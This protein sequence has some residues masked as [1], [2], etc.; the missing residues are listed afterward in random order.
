MSQIMA[1]VTVCSGLIRYRSLRTLLTST[2]GSSNRV[3]DGAFHASLY[4]RSAVSN[5]MADAM[6]IEA[7]TH[8]TSSCQAPRIT[9]R[10]AFQAMWR[11][12]ESDLSLL[13]MTGQVHRPPAIFTWRLFWQFRR[14]PVF[15]C[16]ALDADP[17]LNVEPWHTYQTQSLRP[18]ANRLRR[19]GSRQATNR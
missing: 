10:S 13:P 9:P 12:H 18:D 14:T 7:S 11:Q 8:Q 16:C 2:G 1:R 15:G 3:L 19:V 4:S 5:A 6:F 17:F